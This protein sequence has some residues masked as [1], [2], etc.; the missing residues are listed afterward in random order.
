M[1]NL[2]RLVLPY[3][4]V[5]LFFACCLQASTHAQPVSKPPQRNFAEAFPELSKAIEANDQSG[6]RNAF[7]RLS[8][9]DRQRV[10][11]ALHSSRLYPNTPDS[12]VAPSS[13]E[14][15]PIQPRGGASLANFSELMQLI[16]T[17][18][19]PDVWLNAG[20]TAT[21]S[22][23]RQGVRINPDGII[24][25]FEA[26]SILIGDAKTGSSNLKNIATSKPKLRF[27]GDDSLEASAPTILLT[28]LGQW[29]S[30]TPLRWVSLRKLDRE[31]AEQI[32]QGK[33]GSIA[34][35]LLGG[36][37]R[38]DYVMVDLEGSDC[39]IGG[40]AGNLAASR[41]GDLLHRELLLPP[42]LLE[43]LLVVAAHVLNAQGEFGC[44]I[45]PDPSRLVAAYQMANN[46]SS[47]RLLQR[48]PERWVEEWK[49]KLGPQNANIVGIPQN[50]P[51]GF[52]MIVADAHMKRLAFGLEPSV[53]EVANYWRESDKLGSLQQQSMVRWWFALSNHPIEH[54]P[55]NHLYRFSKSNVRVLSE[56]QWINAN[57]QRLVSA[58][59]DAAA[60][61]FAKNF[62]EHFDKLQKAVPSYGRLRHIFDLAVAM[63]ILRLESDKEAFEPFEVLGTSK[64]APRL[65]VAPKS[66]DS[67]V[68]TR[69]RIDGGM[70][71]I[72]SGGVSIEPS[73]ITKK[74]QVQR[75]LADRLVLPNTGESPSSGSKPSESTSPDSTSAGSLSAEPTF[76]TLFWK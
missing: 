37:T 62:T 19:S 14:N 55:A 16:E 32:A 46:K 43:D 49:Q 25:R 57:G 67:V 22:P 11:T 4:Y 61:A 38:I 47:L 15:D 31:L 13:R 51:T 36:L 52:A 35:E 75:K 56:T 63:E 45:D 54:D 9:Q 24:E 29:Q 26:S 28:E 65:T 70:S 27:P 41:R 40:P 3:S 59:P 42:V 21:M 7:T 20:G 73:L 71:A 66:I 2:I 44:S 69:S 60:D 50:S 8:V 72:V 6:L 5:L 76:E 64:Y 58:S 33:S 12:N 1:Q 30:P 18:V 48:D 53:A 74:L 34:A 23:F 17:T 39:W 68:A 10:L